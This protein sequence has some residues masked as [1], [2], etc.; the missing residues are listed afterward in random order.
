MRCNGS[1]YHHEK[2][3][4]KGIRHRDRFVCYGRHKMILKKMAKQGE[5]NHSPWLML[6]AVGRQ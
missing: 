4:D 1:Q 2:Q 5:Y 6:E 3:D